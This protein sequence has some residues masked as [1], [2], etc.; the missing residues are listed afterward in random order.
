MGLHHRYYGS[1]AEPPPPRM[2]PPYLAIQQ[3]IGSR[4]RHQ[5]EPPEHLPHK[6]LVLLVQ[7]NNQEDG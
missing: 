4:L 5:Y 1:K 7:L 2:R 6:L 3:R